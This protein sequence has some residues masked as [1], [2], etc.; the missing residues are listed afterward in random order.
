DLAHRQIL[1]IAQ[2]PIPR[3]APKGEIPSDQ[4][5]EER[6]VYLPHPSRTS[7]RRG[8]EVD[9]LFLAVAELYPLAFRH[10]GR[11][12][13]VHPYALLLHRRARVLIARAVA[14]DEIRHFTFEAM[15]DIVPDEE[16]RFALPP[17]FDIAAWLHGAFGVARPAPRTRVVVEFDPRV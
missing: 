8:E 4:R 13:R 3:G 10:E 16:Q 14:G 11:A 12:T 7:A 5:L 6:F 9:A 2:R 15:T 17:D 1:K